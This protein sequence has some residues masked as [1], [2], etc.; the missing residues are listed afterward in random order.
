MDDIGVDMVD[1]VVY[2]RR[3]STQEEQ[4]RSFRRQVCSTLELGRYR[5]LATAAA[6][7]ASV[8]AVEARRMWR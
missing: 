6:A 8:V 7:A 5:L 4:N 1:E 3:S 2:V